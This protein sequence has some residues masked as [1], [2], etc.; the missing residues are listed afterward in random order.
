MAKKKKQ[1]KTK[2][3]SISKPKV[4]KLFPIADAHGQTFVSITK[5]F[6]KELK[7]FHERIPSYIYLLGVIATVLG[8][9]LFITW[10][11]ANKELANKEIL[12]EEAMNKALVKKV[13]QIM[14]LP[15]EDPTVVTIVDVSVMKAQ[16]H[17]FYADGED[18]DRMLVY[19]N[20]AIIYRE[21]ENR[22]INIIPVYTVNQE[23]VVRGLKIVV[24]NNTEEKDAIEELQKDI[25]KKH[26]SYSVSEIDDVINSTNSTVFDLTNG[27]LAENVKKL[28]AELGFNYEHK[29]PEGV[30]VNADVIVVIANE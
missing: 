22:I 17:D 19:K 5:R 16:N 11:N 7:N 25:L 15:K 28:A 13:S 9:G 30:E 20:K 1:S 2:K 21:S 12:S 4:R 26:S 8:I 29:A 23:T 14:M 24:K 3:K 27:E 10:H 6:F 18:G